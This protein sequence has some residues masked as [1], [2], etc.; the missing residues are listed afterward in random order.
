[1]TAMDST[2]PLSFQFYAQLSHP[3]VVSLFLSFFEPPC[4]VFNHEFWAPPL[5]WDRTHPRTAVP[6]SP[7]FPYE[8]SLTPASSQF[9]F[10]HPLALFSKIDAFTPSHQSSRLTQISPRTMR[11]L[12]SIFV[13]AVV[14]HCLFPI[15]RGLF[16]AEIRP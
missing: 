9:L 14:L 2:C 1:V 10:Y 16:P 7:L 11:R 4:T 3:R 6:R 15:A 13:S 5:A 12:P 8:R